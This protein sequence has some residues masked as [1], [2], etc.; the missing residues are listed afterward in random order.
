[1]V[2][3]ESANERGSS[4]VAIYGN[5]NSPEQP[6]SKSILAHHYRTVL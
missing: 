1:M 6:G 5:V 3:E 2:A 4:S